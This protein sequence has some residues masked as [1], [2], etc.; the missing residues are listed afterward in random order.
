MDPSLLTPSLTNA[1]VRPI[2]SRTSLFAAAFLFGGFAVAIMAWF[3]AKRLSRLRQ[4]APWLVFC[5]AGSAIVLF[6]AMGLGSE[7]GSDKRIINRGSGFL[8]WLLFSYVH[9]TAYRAMEAFGTPPPSPYKAI[10][11]AFLGSF[12]LLTAVARLYEALGGSL[13]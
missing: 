4:D 11:G 13:A 5:F 9:G 6:Y 12:V 7:S 8:V 10:G 3:N 1:Q 2:Y